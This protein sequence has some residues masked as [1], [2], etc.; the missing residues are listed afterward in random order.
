MVVGDRSLDVD[1]AYNAK[2]DGIL[3][4]VDSRVF[5]HRA[6]HVIKHINQ[7]Y[8]FIDLPYKIKHNYHTHTAR[9][10]HAIGDD[11]Q[12]IIK[13]IEA[14]YQTI[15]FSD[16]LM[17]PDL[18]RN[19]NYFDDIY[20]L[21]EKYKEFNTC[22][23]RE[24]KVASLIA[25]PIIKKKLF[26]EIERVESKLNSN[27]EETDSE[28]YVKGERKEKSRREIVRL[29]KDY[30]EEEIKDILK[31]ISEEKEQEKNDKDSNI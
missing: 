1:G 8:N 5:M 19:D 13:A 6:T 23:G 31:E 14:G 12:Y 9:C 11:E 22:L 25:E 4:D 26:L 21:K 27:F 15:G 24:K 7:L 20:L 10:G 18:N 2:I 3:Y 29:L 17:I 16:H 30:S 28:I